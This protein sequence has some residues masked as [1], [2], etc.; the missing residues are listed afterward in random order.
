[1]GDSDTLVIIGLGALAVF[2]L[3]DTISGVVDPI[4]SVLKTT[5]DVY[6]GTV[7]GIKS[8]LS[9]IGAGLRAADIDG[10]NQG[11]ASDKPI[12]VSLLPNSPFNVS[13][14]QSQIKSVTPKVT[15][16]KSNTIYTNP[17]TKAQSSLNVTSAQSMINMYTNPKIQ[18]IATNVGNAT[19]IQKKT[20]NLPPSLLSQVIG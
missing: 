13:S 7:G 9:S 18:N 17:K 2:T 4:G 12:K 11:T 20:V 6:S 16:S 15:T 1:M 14:G 19:V 5:A 8:G 3:K 10:Y